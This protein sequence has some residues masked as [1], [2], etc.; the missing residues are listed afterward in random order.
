MHVLFV[1][2]A[3]PAQFGRLAFELVRR[4]GWRCTFAFEHLSRCPS[5][6]PAMLKSLDLLPLPRT[7]DPD[8][9]APWPQTLGETLD[10]ARVLA[11]TVRARRGLRPDLVVGHGGLLPTLLLRDVLDCP[12]VDY[13][14][15]CFAPAHRDLTYR[16]DLPA[17][18]PAPFYPRCINAA[19]LLNLAASDA[20][21]APLHWQR[22]SFPPR[23]AGKIE[24]HCDGID[25]D[26]Y[27]PGPGDPALPAGGRVVTFVARGLES[28]RGFDL[29]VRLAQRIARVR[30]DVHFVVAGDEKTY[31]GWDGLHTGGMPFKEWVMGRADCDPSRFRFLGH[32]E[33]EVLA[34]VLRR[35]DL[36]VYLGVP[37]VVSWS[38]F[39]ALACGCTVLAGDA[40]PVREIIEPG[41]HGLV[42]S[43]FDEEG[44][45]E[46]ALRVLADP[47]EY[48]PLGEAGRRRLEEAYSLEVAVPGLKDFFERAAAA[49]RR[50]PEG[51][52]VRPQ[53]G[54]RSGC[55][56]TPCHAAT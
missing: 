10:R 53:E 23:F 21:Y 42:R 13:C 31:Y 19:T 46:T 49:G 2:R 9:P 30:S 6:S 18:E 5:P 32:V 14:E 12:L 38:L 1:H 55:G 29:F 26:L 27:R 54:D 3:L 50:G 37:F 28:L 52:L 56:P 25:T 24:V 43:L 36:H 22:D 35:S 34:G 45:A 39:N 48:R 44:L 20:A 41:V 33:P 11:E 40:A 7:A 17:V 4:H 15:Y 47:A 16:V 8:R 51:D